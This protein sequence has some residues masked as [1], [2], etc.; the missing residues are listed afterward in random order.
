[1]KAQE[2][3]V[4]LKLNGTHHL[5]IY[6]DDVDLLGNNV[7]TIK[8]NTEAVIEASKEVCVEVIT[9]ITKLVLIYYLE[10]SGRNL[11]I[12]VA[13]RRFENVTKFRYFGMTVTNQNLIQEEIKSGLNSGILATLHL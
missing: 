5:L 13:N 10:N 7:N 4:R 3:L 12:K 1:M 11:N 9:E 8:K 6:G 2:L